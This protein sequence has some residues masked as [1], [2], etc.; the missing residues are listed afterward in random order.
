[1][2]IKYNTIQAGGTSTDLHVS[3]EGMNLILD[4]SY[5]KSGI[6]QFKR[7]GDMIREEIEF[8]NDHIIDAKITVYLVDAPET[9]E[10]PNGVK[11]TKNEG[12]FLVDVC[13]IGVDKPYAPDNLVMYVADFTIPKI[14][15][16]TL[17]D[18]E[19]NA[20]KVV[21]GGING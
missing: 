14:G 20:I 13:R 4:M 12:M 18:V 1:M 19:I 7:E 9:V 15:I 17:D 3:V 5:Y 11:V 8:D 21:G 2:T 10:L 16:N 6:H